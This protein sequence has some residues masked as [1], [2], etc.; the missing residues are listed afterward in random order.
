MAEYNAR[1]VVSDILANRYFTNHG[2]LARALEQTLEEHMGARHAVLV[3]SLE[4]GLLVALIAVRTGQHS[5]LV[6]YPGDEDPRLV[7]VG[8]FSGLSV[9]A[10]DTPDSVVQDTDVLFRTLRDERDLDYAGVGHGQQLVVHSPDWSRARPELGI[11][12]SF[13]APVLLE[14][15]T[16][17]GGAVLLFNS[18]ELAEKARNVRSSYGVRK[19]VPVFVTCNGRYSEAQ[20]GAVLGFLRRL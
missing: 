3:G 8:A 20:A 4:L 2:P 19:Q 12:D 16:R 7:H 10:L 17:H 5:R 6:Y 9:H 18:D 14:L 1:K 13:P 15:P 11:P